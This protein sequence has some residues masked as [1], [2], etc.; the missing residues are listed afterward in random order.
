MPSPD[1]FR[2]VDLS[3]PILL[4]RPGF[5]SEGA[6]VHEYAPLQ[7]A[8]SFPKQ[9]W[10]PAAIIHALNNAEKATPYTCQSYR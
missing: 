9:V 7:G 3:L 2:Q 8:D 1:H 4:C 6:M 10:I 5:G